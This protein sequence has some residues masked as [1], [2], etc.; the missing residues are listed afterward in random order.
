MPLTHSLTPSE[1]HPN[2]TQRKVP[3][4]RTGYGHFQ[5]GSG[6]NAEFTLKPVIPGLRNIVI[7]VAVVFVAL[8]LLSF[9]VRITRI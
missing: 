7:G 3:R 4:E 2:R 5:A 8:L 9:A 6:D 1:Y